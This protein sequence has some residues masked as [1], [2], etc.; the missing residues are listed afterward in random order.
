M[1]FILFLIWYNFNQATPGFSENTH[2]PTYNYEY[3]FSG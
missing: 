2:I 1:E 3:V